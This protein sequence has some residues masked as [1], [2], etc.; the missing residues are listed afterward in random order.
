MTRQRQKIAV[1]GAG[2]AGLASAYFL[3]RR[4]EVTLFE[5][6]PVLGGHAN[7][8]EIG[9]DGHRFPVDTGFLVLNDQT[10]PNL[11]HLFQELGVDTYATDMSFSVSADEGRLEWAGTNLDTVFAQ[12]RRL[13]SPAYWNLLREILRFNRR[14]SL[15][16]ALCETW[17]LTLGELLER[18]GYG[19]MFRRH[20]LLPMAA[21]IWSCSAADIL[22][23]PAATF[24]R[25]CMN[26]GLLQIAG[27][28]QW[29][30][31]SGGSR[32]YVLRLAATLPDIRLC[33]AVTGVAR[34]A[35]DG[36]IAVR[37]ANHGAA[38][39]FDS[40]V[41]ATHAPQSL[42]MLEEAS[43]E[44]YEILSA[45][46]YQYNRACLHTDASL[47][48]RLRKVWSSW[49][50]LDVATA[51][52]TD[53][54]CVSYWL[55][56]LQQLPCTTPVMVTL[57]PAREPHPDS[58]L[59][60]F[61]YEHPVLDQ[62]AITAQASLATIQGKRGIWFAGAWTGYGFHEDGLKSAL[63]IAQRFGCAPSWAQA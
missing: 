13:V 37:T 62:A 56:R 9:V 46:R 41:L 63:L 10:Y 30:T 12:R 31:V 60:R 34:R 5:A 52:G 6:A 43:H 33:A 28:P 57:N 49:N 17:P 14:A 2:I 20:Y 21:A 44:E 35:D 51:D 45:V 58:V 16:L 36:K 27:R 18:D 4:H 39:A 15:N 11:I 61:D 7:T 38:E 53:A 48:P 23:F 8:V 54:V 26:H 55:N 59:A 47:M 22:Q 32:E 42:A 24:L 3:A 19:A 29:R 1:I 40:V 50:Y 25:F